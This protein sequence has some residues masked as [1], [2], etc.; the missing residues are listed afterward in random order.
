M[1]TLP[2]L[3][4]LTVA[5]G[6]GNKRSK[7]EATSLYDLLNLPQ[8]ATSAEIRKNFLMLA[9]EVHPDK[10]PDDP[11]AHSRFVELKKAYDTLSDADAR[12][13]YDDRVSDAGEHS[14]AFYDACSFFRDI[15][16]NTED[17]K[18][19]L[20]AYRGSYVEEQDL[21]AFY[22][23]NEGDLTLLLFFIIGSRDEDVDRF[24]AFFK[25]AIADERLIGDDTN[26]DRN[27]VK[28][29]AAL[30]NEPWELDLENE[31]WSEDESEE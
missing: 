18:A 19:Y 25:R 2:N 21:I 1:L 26:L 7:P 16:I 22:E 20:E 23:K 3:S 6:A 17:I 13:K 31:P 30:E 14:S 15:P 29:E 27:K 4:R 5:T 9:K 8:D 10:N 24:L 12:K 28:S 11:L